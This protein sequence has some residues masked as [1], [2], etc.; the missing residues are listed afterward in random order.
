MHALP[1]RAAAWLRIARLHFYPPV[2]VLYLVGALAARREGAAFDAG[3]CLLG[4]TYLFLV[5]LATSMANEYVDH[6]A[7]RVNA[8]AGPF[9]GGSRV[10]VE[11]RLGAPAVRTAIVL[12]V[13]LAVLAGSVLV[14]R[15][16]AAR[17]PAMSAMAL[18]ALVLGLGYTMPPLKLSFRGLGEPDVAFLHS[19]FVAVFGSVVQTG[20]STATPL[21][22]SLPCFFA[23]LGA[24]TLAAIPDHAADT[25]IGKR[26]WS[27]RFGRRAAAAV[28]AAAA[29][30]AALTG[31]WLWLGGR[32]PGRPGAAFL[33]AAA[34]GLVLCGAL[35][36]ARR[37][38]AL[39]GRIDGLLLNALTY[40]LWFTLIPLLHVLS[41]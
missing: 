2:L 5:V 19:I 10:L 39:E 18:A 37:G 27:V 6:A 23:V 24:I 28:A 3:Q 1:G 26:S 20:A 35:V 29:I 7:D 41:A 17:A 9:S 33:P 11:G 13:G 36:R 4:A 32:V 25:T 38:R 34:H 40:T 30:L 16:P 12:A 8:N 15:A 22:L 21:L 14:A 31:L